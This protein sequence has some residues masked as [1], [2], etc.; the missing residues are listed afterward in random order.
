MMVV[1]AGLDILYVTTSHLPLWRERGLM[2]DCSQLVFLSTINIHT[3]IIILI[4]A[5]LPVWILWTD[6]HLQ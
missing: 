1:Q 3:V 6:M 4:N 5:V 2:P